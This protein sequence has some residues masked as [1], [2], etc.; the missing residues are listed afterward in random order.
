MYFQ[1]QIINL[2]FLQKQTLVQVVLR[3]YR[4]NF[5]LCITS[6]IEKH[7]GL[8][9]NKLNNI[10]EYKAVKGLKRRTYTLVSTYKNIKLK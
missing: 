6:V 4:T 10:I 5:Y 2:F 1:D 8:K 7:T 9:N 3:F